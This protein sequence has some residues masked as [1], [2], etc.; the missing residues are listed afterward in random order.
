[1]IA[2]AL[3]SSIILIVITCELLKDAFPMY[4]SVSGVAKALVRQAARF[5]PPL[6]RR[7]RIYR[8]RQSWLDRFYAG[9]PD[10][11]RLDTNPYEHGKYRDI[12][13]ALQNRR[14]RKAWE[15]GCS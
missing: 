8:T 12:I 13:A 1:M 15:V 5:V 9:D 14:Y 6:D 3:P 7:L 11:F 4:V 10:P 2:V